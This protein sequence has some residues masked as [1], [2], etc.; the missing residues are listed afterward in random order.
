MT[1]IAFESAFLTGG[2]VLSDTQNCLKPATFE[3]LV[4]RQDW[5]ATNEG[6]QKVDVGNETEWEDKDISG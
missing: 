5:I 3:A 2:R 6:L 1:S 4:C